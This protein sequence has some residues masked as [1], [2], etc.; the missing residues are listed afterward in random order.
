MRKSVLRRYFIGATALIMASVIILGSALCWQAYKYSINEK[1]QLLDSKAHQISELTADLLKNYSGMKLSS[2]EYVMKTMSEGGTLHILICGTDGQVVI[3]SDDM[4]RAY[5]GVY[6][7]EAVLKK[8][9]ESGRYA[10]VGNLGGLYK[11]SNYTV[12]VPTVNSLGQLAGYVFVTAPMSSMRELLYDI[13]KMFLM[14]AISVFMLAVIFSYLVVRGMTRPI[15][16]I[17]IAAKSFA[18]GDFTAR[19]PAPVNRPDEIGEMV[20]AFN[21]M[22]DS[23]ERS[24]ELRRSFVANVS[25]ELRSPMTSIGGFVDGI[26]DGTIPE[27]R[28]EHYLKIISGEVKRLSRLVSRMLDI[29]RLQAKDVSAESTWFDMCE[30]IRRVIVGFEERMRDKKLGMNVQLCAYSVNIC[31]NEDMIYQA[32]Y[33]L[34]ENAIKFSEPESEISINLSAN[35]G[36]IL[37]SIKNSGQ[38]IPPDQLAYVF[39]RFHKTDRSR[40]TDKSGLGLGLYIVKT[41]VNQHGGD[42]GVMSAEGVTEFS[43]VLPAENRGNLTKH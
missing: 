33:N 12:G 32:V 34:T 9:A 35:G 16:Q 25:H 10:S 27:E 3:T 22:A 42:V 15:K 11:G 21:N 43:F 38:T 19:V 18:Q 17:S 20:I 31:A 4:G 6:V 13:L 26:L 8:M 23:L 29:T 1:R 14:S 24:E 37:F 2:F 7:N 40:G 39:D 41:I 30:L 28:R 5:K 36:K